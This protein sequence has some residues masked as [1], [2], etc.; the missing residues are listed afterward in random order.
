MSFSLITF[1]LILV[2][3]GVLVLMIGIFLSSIDKGVNKENT[4]IEGG[5]VIMLGPI[6]IGFGT[7]KEMMIL[8]IILAIIL[9]IISFLFMHYFRSF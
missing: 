3:V 8:A 5:G 4:K 1:G 7:S 6:P 9:M 2:I